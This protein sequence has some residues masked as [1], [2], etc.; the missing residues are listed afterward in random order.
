MQTH[1]LCNH[2]HSHLLDTGF[3]PFGLCSSRPAEPVRFDTQILYFCQARAEKR[4]L[5]AVAFS[6]GIEAHLIAEHL[7]EFLQN[8]RS[9]RAFC[10][11]EFLA[12][13]GFAALQAGQL[14]GAAQTARS[15]QQALHLLVQGI[16]RRLVSSLQLQLLVETLLFLLNGM[17]EILYRQRTQIFEQAHRV[18]NFGHGGVGSQ[19]R[20]CRFFPTGKSK[21]SFESCSGRPASDR[22]ELS[23][24]GNPAG[25]TSNITDKQRL[26]GQRLGQESCSFEHRSDAIMH[27][28]DTIFQQQRSFGTSGNR[29]GQINVLE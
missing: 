7:P 25:V 19:R 12:Q 13:G 18:L 24:L 10:T 9:V 26:D 15:G 11:C 16:C 2:I 6:K 23:Q 1:Q 4:L 29:L 5:S 17:L 14:L 8:P 27:S 3:Q 21:I 20:Q 28:A 22:F